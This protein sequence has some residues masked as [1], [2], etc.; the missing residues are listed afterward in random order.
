MFTVLSRRANFIDINVKGEYI[1]SL[2]HDE[3]TT[4][5]SMQLFTNSQLS[6]VDS[7]LRDWNSFSTAWSTKSLSALY[8][9]EK[10]ITRSAMINSGNMRLDT[11]V[12]SRYSVW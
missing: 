3:A 6:V 8:I 12:S 9:G 5:G 10:W 2:A 4:I 7:P 1:V 11:A